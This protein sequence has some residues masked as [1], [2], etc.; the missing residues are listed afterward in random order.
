MISPC[1]DTCAFPLPPVS[2]LLCYNS[3][4]TYVVINTWSPP[5]STT[6][7]L[8]RAK[9]ASPYNGSSSMKRI[10][11]Q[12]MMVL[13][14][15]LVCLT[16][17]NA[18]QSLFLGSHTRLCYAIDYCTYWIW[19]LILIYGLVHTTL[20]VASC[21]PLS[22]GQGSLSVSTDNG[23]KGLQSFSDTEANNRSVLFNSYFLKLI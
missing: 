13:L 9:R 7:Q 22:W 15:M 5:L 2:N 19:I 17:P 23:L 4:T 18:W 6:C 20:I 11:V 3:H 14:K 21:K 16:E 8:R 10:R 1:F 12:T